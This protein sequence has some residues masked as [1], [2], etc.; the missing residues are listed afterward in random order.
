MCA[1][2]RTAHACTRS[3]NLQRP[4]ERGA[5]L[6]TCLLWPRRCLH[7]LLVW[8]DSLRVR[9]SLASHAGGWTAD[10]QRP[11]ERGD[12]RAT[13]PAAARGERGAAG[14]RAPPRGLGTPSAAYVFV[15]Y[16]RRLQGAP[17]RPPRRGAAAWQRRGAWGHRAARRG[18]IGR[19][20]R[21]PGGATP[22]AER[23]TLGLGLP[24]SMHA[25]EGARPAGAHVVLGAMLRT[26]RAV[27]YMR[28]GSLKRVEG[29]GGRAACTRPYATH[30]PA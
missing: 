10:A 22:A 30:G 24:R 9:D 7:S 2:L 19:R 3:A 21:R 15:V 18:A 27:T 1:A 13:P 20:A 5:A 8:A 6:A 26:H 28:I 12:P 4:S 17:A 25:R 16:G 11:V 29:W 23:E 14:R